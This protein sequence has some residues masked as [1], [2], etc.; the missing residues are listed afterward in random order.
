MP[1]ELGLTPDGRWDVTVETY[2][3]AAREAG[4]QHVGLGEAR[5]TAQT[6]EAMTAGGVS[7]HEV[8]ALRVGRGER[9]LEQAH[10]LADAAASVG[11][12][13]VLTGGFRAEVNNEV[14][15][16]LSNAAEVIL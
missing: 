2:L 5:A 9:L 13:W 7:C 12:P 6:A 8:L 1:V 10:R 4:F 16:G 3:L 15:A 14:L 11:A